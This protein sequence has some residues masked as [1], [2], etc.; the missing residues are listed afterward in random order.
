MV[1]H[2]KCTKG[3]ICT[4]KHDRKSI[5][6]TWDY[7]FKKMINS[8]YKNSKEFILSCIE[9]DRKLNNISIPDIKEESVED[10]F[11]L[12]MSLAKI[13]HIKNVHR[14]GILK[15]ANDEVMITNILFDSGALHSSY[16]SK[17]F[18]NKNRHILKD[19][20]K[21]NDGFVKLG[22]NKTVVKVDET[23][24]L[25]VSFIDNNLKE[26]IAEVNFVVWEMNDMNM[27]IGLP[28]ILNHYLDVFIEMLKSKEDSEE[29]TRFNNLQSPWSLPIQEEAKE[30]IDTPLPSSFSGPLHFLEL[31]HEEAIKEYMDL[32]KSHINEECDKNTD[33]MKLLKSDNALR[34]F[35]PQEWNGIQGIPPV[36][37]EFN[38][39]LSPE[40]NQKRG[41]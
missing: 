2:N 25:P 40:L 5:C 20:I 4:Y 10:I 26:H 35:V 14:D 34:V 28:D 17:S 31:S 6:D 15:I 8:D 32:L 39:T 19:N 1:Y 7:Y 41:Q 23:I 27:I 29:D 22:D 38:E 11:N 30:E 36:E 18:I 3:N 21:K 12:E 13:S 37:L 9:K 33:I 16:I 24:Q